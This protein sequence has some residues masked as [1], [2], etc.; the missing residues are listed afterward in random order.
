MG[1][2]GPNG[3]GKSTLMKIL[4]C[5]I[6]AS[7]GKAHV[8]GLDVVERSMDARLQIGYLPEHNP[9]YLDMYVREY[10][11]MV[12]SI[13]KV[14]NTVRATDVAIERTGLGPECHKKIAQLSKG[15]RQRVGLAQTLLHDP[16]VLIL[17]EP[18]T[19]LDPNQIVEIRN[20]IREVGREKTV[21][22]SSHIMQEVEAICE[23]VIILS[24]GSIVADGTTT[25]L[26]MQAAGDTISI[27]FLEKTTANLFDQVAFVGHAQKA[28]SGAFSIQAANPQDDIRA[29]LFG[30][31][32]EHQLT[33]IEMQR[34]EHRLEDVFRQL[35]QHP[36]Q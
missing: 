32:V 3:A 23:R 13:Y 33:I 34:Q 7:S 18:T 22:L 30:W 9:L 1:L 20:L 19:G 6:S 2:L 35:T 29:E 12:A 28:T 25:S 15:Y 16:E 21:L 27:E 10:L 26:K 36:A 11:Q 31:A 14:S 5:S 4:S 24:K 17:D 8:G